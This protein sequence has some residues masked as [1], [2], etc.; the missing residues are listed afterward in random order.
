MRRLSF[1]KGVSLHLAWSG[2]GSTPE[3]RH[4]LGDLILQLVLR[5]LH[6]AGRAL[7]LR[8]YAI[9]AVLFNGGTTELLVS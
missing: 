2:K 9:R 6:G 7:S 4:Y 8:L 5:G 1:R 3:K